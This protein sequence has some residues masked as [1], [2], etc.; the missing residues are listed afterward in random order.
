MRRENINAPLRADI[1]MRVDIISLH[2]KLCVTACVAGLLRTKTLLKKTYGNTS[3]RRARLKIILVTHH[4][5]FTGWKAR[6][7]AASVDIVRTRAIAVLPVQ[8]VKNILRLTPK[9]L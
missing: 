8:S 3:G 7:K 9:R 1:A 4:E 5:R 6:A 2:A